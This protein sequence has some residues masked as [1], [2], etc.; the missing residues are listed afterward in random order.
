MA[1]AELRALIIGT[2]FGANVV[3]GVYRELGMTVEVVSPRDA[4]AVRAA[5]RRPADFVSI[6]SPPFLHAEHVALALAEGRDVICD[7]PFGRSATQ[8][9]A[10]LDAAQTAGVLHFVN[11]E[12]R[13]DPARAALRALLHGGAIGALRHIHWFACNAGS[14]Q[15][16][17][18]HGWL[19]D[20]DLAGG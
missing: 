7:K 3:A 12:F 6:H 8:A 10:M 13:H 15:P 19:F 20:R 2:G 4:D 11:F 5:V 18:P 16:L 9:R 14:R 1:T 17:R